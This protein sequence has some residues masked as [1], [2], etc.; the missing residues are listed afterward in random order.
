MEFLEEIWDSILDF[1]D[2]LTP[3]QKWTFGVSIAVV[4]VA[5]GTLYGSVS[6]TALVPLGINLSPPEQSSVMDY[7]D[8]QNI[9]YQVRDGTLHVPRQ[10]SEQLMFDLAGEGVIATDDRLTEW[11][12]QEDF[13]TKNKRQMKWNVTREKRLELTLTK[14]DHIL[15][16]DVRITPGETAQTLREGRAAK[17]SVRLELLPGKEM[18]RENVE[19]IAKVISGAVEHLEP[20]NVHIVDNQGNHYSVPDSD[21]ASQLSAR[22]K[23]QKKKQEERFQQKIMTLFPWA[24]RDL[25]SVVSVRL[26]Q[27]KEKIETT[28]QE[29]NPKQQQMEETEVNTE[30][31]A[32]PGTKTQTELQEGIV[33][34]GVAQNPG[35]TGGQKSG[36][37]S[38]R[39]KSER[40]QEEFI[41]ERTHTVKKITPGSIKQVRASVVLPEEPLE[42]QVF[43][44][45]LSSEERDQKENRRKIEK[46][47]AEYRKLILNI[48]ASPLKQQ[49]EDEQNAV[50]RLKQRSH[51]ELV[52]ASVSP[53]PPPEKP[54]AS[55]RAKSFVMRNLQSIL[56]SLFI[57]VGLFVVYTVVKRAYPRD[58]QSEMEK[59]QEKLALEEQ[60]MDEIPTDVKEQ[61]TRELREKIE[62]VVEEDTEEAASLV[63]SWLQEES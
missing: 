11:L 48:L 42:R 62:Q 50:E 39:T 49:A 17:A 4:I 59:I 60:R 58:I 13:D 5:L 2:R 38:R 25:R 41:E 9:Q 47:L 51:V 55:E 63:E 3:A 46:H 18:S 29:G 44:R 20:K 23:R 34:G 32:P 10:K 12:Y 14:M 7:L 43:G 16:A 19:G 31:G 53:P 6:K 8:E 45:V 21:T 57:L 15:S 24:G 28:T 36:R 56:I 27:N 54:P 33:E 30:R 37:T 61:Q 35:S 40:M 22:L 52:T 1:Y 26:R